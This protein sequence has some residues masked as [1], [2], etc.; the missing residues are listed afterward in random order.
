VDHPHPVQGL[1]RVRE[2]ALEPSS[3]L[4]GLVDRVGT[5]FAV[6]QMLPLTEN[7]VLPVVLGLDQ[8]D[9][10]RSDDH[11]IDLV[12]VGRGP[13]LQRRDHEVAVGKSLDQGL[14]HSL[15]AVIDR[16]PAVGIPQFCHA[17]NL[18]R[19]RSVDPGS[20][21]GVG[22]MWLGCHPL[23]SSATIPLLYIT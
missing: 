17:R 20:A 9:Y 2:H 13:D 18:V 14:D 5:A 16:L 23:V 21:A 4:E 3:L 10:L 7:D 6:Q 11:R 12:G 22:S 19:S 8:D 15:F 1:G